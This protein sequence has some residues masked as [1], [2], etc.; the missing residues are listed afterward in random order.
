MALT[1]TI[2]RFE[3]NL[4]DVDRGVYDALE[5]RVA[6]HPS[7]TDEHMVTRVLA[8]ALE[9][10]EGLAFGRG[11]STPEDPA[12]SAPGEHGTIALWVEIGHPA[13]ERLHKITKQA[14]DVAVYTHKDPAG[15]L[16]DLGSGKVHR[17][18]E[19]RVVAFETAFVAR[20]VETLDRKNQWEVLRNEGSLYVT[21]AGT[22]LETVPGQLSA[23]A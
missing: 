2:F 4:S 19:V 9:H 22:V 3:L 12:L 13:P 5:L 8:M 18:D 16:A 14:D 7:E 6:R 15:L 10:R 11:I 23:S 1:A 21:I 20:L 17:G